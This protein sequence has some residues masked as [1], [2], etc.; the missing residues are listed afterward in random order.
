MT[1]ELAKLVLQTVAQSVRSHL[2][3]KVQ[4][5]D[6]Q[7]IAGNA[8]LK[9]VRYTKKHK[10]TEDDLG[11]VNWITMMAVREWIKKQK[12][13]RFQNFT[14]MPE[15]GKLDVL[16][17]DHFIAEVDIKDELE[18]LTKS[19]KEVAKLAVAGFN[20]IE[21]AEKIG[22]NVLYVRYMHKRVKEKLKGKYGSD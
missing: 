9:V 12:N 6:K 5:Q 3:F 21:I 15:K 10:L 14:D 8:L 7:D 13:R 11:L 1:P 22:S 19:Q 2:R 20:H 17:S 18:A 4:S 16:L